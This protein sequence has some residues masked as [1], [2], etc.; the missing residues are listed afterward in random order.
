MKYP[1][2]LVT[3]EGP[4]FITSEEFE[5]FCESR[6][7][8]AYTEIL[9]DIYDYETLEAHQAVIL[10]ITPIKLSKRGGYTV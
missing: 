3:N 2:V 6:C 1:F 10:T 4:K 7:D 9:D 5:E 8:G